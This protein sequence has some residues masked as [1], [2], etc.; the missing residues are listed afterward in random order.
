VQGLY[1]LPSEQDESD[2]TGTWQLSKR[3]KLISVVTM[4]HAARNTAT[5]R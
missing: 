2:D 4:H 1:I 3:K 5:E